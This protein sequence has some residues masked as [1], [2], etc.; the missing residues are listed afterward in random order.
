MKSAAWWRIP[1]TQEQE[2]TYRR[3]TSA[4]ASAI[5]RDERHEP[6]IDPIEDVPRQSHESEIFRHEHL[7]RAKVQD[8]ESRQNEPRSGRKQ[9]PST[10]A[11]QCRC[12]Q[13]VDRAKPARNAI[14]S[15][16]P[17]R[18]E[19][20][21]E[22]RQKREVRDAVPAVEVSVSQIRQETAEPK[23]PAH[24]EGPPG[25]RESSVERKE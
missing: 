12:P 6:R 8:D 19:A 10:N 2:D 20:G 21:Q 15:M 17:G 23:R 16:W 3:E 13:T 5:M 11:R 4:E 22:H 1:S 7:S 25:P 18:N 9:P 24:D 14:R